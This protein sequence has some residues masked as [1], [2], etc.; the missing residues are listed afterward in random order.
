VPG[1]TRSTLFKKGFQMTSSLYSHDLYFSG[2]HLPDLS[3]LLTGKQSQRAEVRRLRE[4][5]FVLLK[6]QYEDGRVLSI[7]DG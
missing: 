3:D 6:Y 7:P 5:D 4:P 2:G 1:T